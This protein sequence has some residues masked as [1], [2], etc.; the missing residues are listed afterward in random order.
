[1]KKKNIDLRQFMLFFFNSL[2]Y[3]ISLPVGRMFNTVLYT[4]PSRAV[5]FFSVIIDAHRQ[6]YSSQ[7]YK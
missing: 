4:P 1:M 7:D 6:L 2:G 3:Q 5:S